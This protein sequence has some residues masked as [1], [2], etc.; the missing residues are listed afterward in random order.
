MITRALLRLERTMNLLEGGKGGEGKMGER[1]WGGD[2]WERG[3]VGRE[4][5]WGRDGGRVGRDGGRVGRDVGREVG[6]GRG[7]EGRDDAYTYCNRYVH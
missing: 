1:G 4:G 7:G 6:D 5:G 2:V 3:M